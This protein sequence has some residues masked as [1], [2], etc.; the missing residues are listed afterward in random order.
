MKTDHLDIFTLIPQ[1]PPMVMVDKLIY[2]DEKMSRSALQIREGNIFVENN[3]LTEAG[4]VENIAQTAAAR[5]GYIC[6]LEKK[7][8]PV[9]YIGAVQ[10]LEISDLPNINE[11]IETEV[12]V[13]N[14]ILN[15]MIIKGKISLN[16]KPIAECEMKIFISNQQ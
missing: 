13:K 3:R 9:G 5:I 7:P 10:Y 8:V 6:M 14:E 1:R 16:E 12:S 15:V 11:K 4:L 2:S